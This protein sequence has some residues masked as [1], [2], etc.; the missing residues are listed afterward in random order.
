MKISRE[1]RIAAYAVC[2]ADGQMLLARWVGRGGEKLWTLP[3]G[4]VE[5]GEH[6]HDAAIREVEEE[7]GYSIA[8]DELLG[9]DSAVN[10][11]GRPAGRVVELHHVRIVYS[12]HVT[13]GDLR[14]EEGGSTDMAA[15]VPLAEIPTLDHVEAVDT[16][17]ALYATRPATGL[18]ASASR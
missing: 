18:P 5:H 16:A 8:V 12:A 2:I 7:T 3:G 17:L 10:Q 1:T 15:W 14:Y 4:K 9:V 6:P 11:Y 13:G